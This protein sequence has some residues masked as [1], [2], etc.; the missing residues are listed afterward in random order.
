MFIRRNSQ[1][2][3]YIDIENDDGEDSR[4]IEREIGMC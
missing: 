2:C 3:V 4:L 1:E